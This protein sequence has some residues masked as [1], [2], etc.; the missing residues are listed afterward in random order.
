[1]L[2]ARE[3][4]SGVQLPRLAGRGPSRLYSHSPSSTP[5]WIVA[6]QHTIF[7]LF[8]AD[9]IYTC[10]FSGSIHYICRS[11]SMYNFLSIEAISIP[12]YYQDLALDAARVFSAIN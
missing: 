3:I 10:L 6:C 8:V 7:D 12:S 9:C 4:T 5:Y 11:V 2:K 1:M